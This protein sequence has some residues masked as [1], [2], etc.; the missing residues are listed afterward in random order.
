MLHVTC[1]DALCGFCYSKMV[2]DC[3]IE[4]LWIFNDWDYWVGTFGIGVLKRTYDSKWLMGFISCMSN[5]LDIWLLLHVLLD[6]M[7]KS[8]VKEIMC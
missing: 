1:K 5:E 4:L 3:P 6:E 2:F 8:L 7:Y